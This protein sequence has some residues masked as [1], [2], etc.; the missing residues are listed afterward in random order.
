MENPPDKGEYRVFNQLDQ[1]Y[2]LTDLAAKVVHVTRRIG[3]IAEIASISNPRLEKEEHY[4]EVEHI[5][6]KQL[7]FQPSRTVQESIHQILTDLLQYRETLMQYQHVIL[8]K[9]SWTRGIVSSPEKIR[10]R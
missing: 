1:V 2:N 9:T 8:P 3:L 7:G 5:K 6:L 10:S 4:Y